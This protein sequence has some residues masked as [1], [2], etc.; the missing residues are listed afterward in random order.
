MYSN[1]FIDNQISISILNSR[2]YWKLVNDI[3]AINFILEN[4]SKHM[5][6]IHTQLPL[7]QECKQFNRSTILTKNFAIFSCTNSI[8]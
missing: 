6:K 3:S 5:V 7:F 8:D 1:S 4:P 2:M